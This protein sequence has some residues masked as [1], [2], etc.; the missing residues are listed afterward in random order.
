MQDLVCDR[1]FDAKKYVQAHVS[2]FHGVFGGY[3]VYSHM[4]VMR[5]LPLS[6]MVRWTTHLHDASVIKASGSSG[7][8]EFQDMVVFAASQNMNK[9]SPVKT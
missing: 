2:Q 8:L 5:W 4:A 1:G 6:R 9:V 3:A 7:G